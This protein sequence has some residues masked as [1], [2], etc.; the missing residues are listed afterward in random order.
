[1]F[2]STPLED[3]AEY[4]EMAKEVEEWFKYY[5]AKSKEDLHTTE[6]SDTTEPEYA[7]QLPW[8]DNK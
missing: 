4:D 6:T 5:N 2:S 7:E 8:E 3:G 1:M